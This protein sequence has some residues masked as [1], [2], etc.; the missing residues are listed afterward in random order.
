MQR[1]VDLLL[2]GSDKVL[3][4]KGRGKERHDI[5]EGAEHVLQL[6]RLV[7]VL[8]DVLKVVRHHGARPEEER[9][10]AR[11]VDGVLEVA[12]EVELA[13][14]VLDVLN[15]IVLDT[16]LRTHTNG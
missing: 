6:L 10:V 7:G 5:A 12:D 9:A 11:L 16:R 2:V 13:H 1:R 14:L 3:G 8:E 15:L 4:R